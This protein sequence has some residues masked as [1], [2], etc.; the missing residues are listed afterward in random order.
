MA[1]FQQT[2]V[3]S[4]FDT[5]YPTMEK[6]DLVYGLGR[7]QVDGR[8][9]S[10]S[11]T[12][13]QLARPVKSPS[14]GNIRRH[15]AWRAVTDSS[16]WLQHSGLLRARTVE[17]RAPRESLQR[18]TAVLIAPFDSRYSEAGFRVFIASLA[19]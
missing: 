8:E 14:S 2:I 17:S 19:S 6:S 12:A 1:K 18:R 5:E 11:T 7:K 9:S 3:F 4:E 10:E 13:P 16:G 15:I